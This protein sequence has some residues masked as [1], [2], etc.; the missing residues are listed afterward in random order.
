MIRIRRIVAWYRDPAPILLA[1]KGNAE[2]QARKTVYVSRR[3]SLLL[4]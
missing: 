4:S 3:D 2:K 1:E